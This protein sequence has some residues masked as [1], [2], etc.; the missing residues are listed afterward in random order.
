[1]QGFSVSCPHLVGW[2]QEQTQ[3]EADTTSTMLLL[4]P[5]GRTCTTGAKLASVGSTNLLLLNWAG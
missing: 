4:I 3:N 5:I 1:M 2:I